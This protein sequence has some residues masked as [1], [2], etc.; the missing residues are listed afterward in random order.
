MRSYFTGLGFH[1]SNIMGI[2][3]TDK[4]RIDT[5][6]IREAEVRAAVADVDAAEV[7]ALMQVGRRASGL[8][9]DVV[10]KGESIE[11]EFWLRGAAKATR[12]RFAPSAL[13]GKPKLA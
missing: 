4:G 11:A 9:F 7:D 6:L 5:A 2:A 8:E 1:V 10:E 13:G 3:R 12:P